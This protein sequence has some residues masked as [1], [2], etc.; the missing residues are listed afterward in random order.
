MTNLSTK[1]IPPGLFESSP[2]VTATVGLALEALACAGAR[3]LTPNA[4][5]TGVE[6]AAPHTLQKSCVSTCVTLAAF[7][8][9]CQQ[10]AL[11]KEFLGHACFIDSICVGGGRNVFIRRFQHRL[12]SP[13]TAGAWSLLLRLFRELKP[14]A[15]PLSSPPSPL[16][17]PPRCSPQR[18]SPERRRR[19]SSSQR[20]PASKGPSRGEP[21]RPRERAHAPPAHMK[22]VRKCSRPL[23]CKPRARSSASGKVRLDDDDGSDGNDLHL[24]VGPCS[25]RRR[26]AVAAC[27]SLRTGSNPSLRPD[28]PHAPTVDRHSLN[29]RT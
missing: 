18:T 15:F 22:N 26:Q 2:A 7:Y 4:L 27:G 5:T 1:P 13:L 21:V 29:E 17:P 12:T 9:A 25:P 11:Y 14:D 28:L 24:R 10:D 3:G 19:A 6:R 20:L 16:P 23:P 8:E